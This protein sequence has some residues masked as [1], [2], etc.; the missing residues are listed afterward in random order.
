MIKLTREITAE[1]FVHEASDEDI[2]EI[3]EAI[4]FQVSMWPDSDNKLLI[5][6][7]AETVDDPLAETTLQDLITEHLI[8]FGRDDE[9]L[10]SLQKLKDNLVHCISLVDELMQEGAAVS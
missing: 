7:H 6:A 4:S 1:E 5:Y 3:L 9:R 2:I 10:E 8:G